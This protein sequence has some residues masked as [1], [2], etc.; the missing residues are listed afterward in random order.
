[1]K[2]KTDK[3]VCKR[4]RTIPEVIHALEECGGIIKQTCQYLQ[5]AQTTFYKTYRHLPEIEEALDRIQRDAF[6]KIT[7]TIYRNAIAGDP[8]FCQMFLRYS[9]VAKRCGWLSEEHVKIE[10]KKPLTETEREDLKNN[11]FGKL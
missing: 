3:H 10:T 7:E 1:M 2:E 8:K 11:L 6:D 9:P 5:I 4:I